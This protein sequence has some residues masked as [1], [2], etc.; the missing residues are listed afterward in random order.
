M[1]AAS[2]PGGR[3]SRA[4]PG[5]VTCSL[6]W[7][8]LSGMTCGSMPNHLICRVAG[9]AS[10]SAT[11]PRPRAAVSALSGA[12]ASEPVLASPPTSPVSPM[13]LA[14]GLT[15]EEVEELAEL[16]LLHGSPKI[17][18]SGPTV[19]VSMRGPGRGVAWGR[20]VTFL[21]WLW[22]PGELGGLQNT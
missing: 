11:V 4:V 7:E 12:L 3:A 16:R 1:A 5:V 21:R 15:Q 18:V 22:R 14:C 6:R 8:L 17:A 13:F 9:E 2:V 10:S 20:R 19:V